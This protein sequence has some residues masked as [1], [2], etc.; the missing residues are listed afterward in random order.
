MKPISLKGG[1]NMPKVTEDYINKKKAKIIDA[2]F[3]IFQQKPLYEMTMLDVIKQAGLSKGGIYRYFSDIDDVI[4]ELINRET[5][6]NNYK[7]NIDDIINCNNNYGSIIEELFKLLGKHINESSD[8]VCK[9][10]FELTVLLANHPEKV[11]KIS[12][13]LTEHENGQYLINSLFQKIIEGIT[14]GEFKPEL[15]IEDIFNYIRAYIEGVVKIVVLERCY[16][17][18][19][20]SMDAEKMMSMLSQT[21]LNMLKKRARNK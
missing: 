14:I 9:I 20:G 2:A 8:T 11:E 12:S 15:P 17:D 16:S 18:N 13:K 6:R 7:D 3:V 10:Q 1:D 19:T 4:V 5:R 21:I